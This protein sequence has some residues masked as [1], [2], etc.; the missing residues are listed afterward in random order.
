MPQPEMS[1]TTCRVSFSEPGPFSRAAERNTASTGAS[2]D[3]PG[4]VGD[5]GGLR[6]LAAAG[7]TSSDR[8]RHLLQQPL[9]HAARLFAAGDAQVELGLGAA[10]DGRRVGLA[11]IAALAAVLLRHGRE[12][13]ARQRPALGKLH[14]LVDR[15]GDIVPGRAV[16][17]LAAGQ[18]LRRGARAARLRAA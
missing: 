3:L 15:Q 9:Q 17:G 12:Q 7:A 13:L 2:R 11:Q 8:R 14:A 4:D 16:V 10:G 6:R 1:S 5:L 18:R